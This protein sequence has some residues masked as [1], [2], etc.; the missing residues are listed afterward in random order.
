MA[1]LI[2]RLLIVLLIVLYAQNVMASSCTAPKKLQQVSIN[3]DNLVIAVMRVNNRPVADS[4]DLYAHDGTFFVAISQLGFL[5]DLPWH[6][7]IDNH[8]FYSAYDN[9]DSIDKLC[10]FDISL[11]STGTS[12]GYWY[13][14]DF[15]TY[16]DVLTLS[17]LFVGE[18]NFNEKLQQLN[19]TSVEADL[20]LKKNKHLQINTFFN[21]PNVDVYPIVQ[22]AYRLFSHPIVNYRVTASTQRLNGRTNTRY[23]TN[24]NANLDLMGLA[25]EYRFI[26]GSNYTAN[27]AKF[28][29]NN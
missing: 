17:H 27:F 26:H 25:S 23:Q 13:T 7:D 18:V 21:E 19:F 2:M 22:D 16:I 6:F 4:I 14:D 11:E 29:K 20:G 8:Q 3:E 5:L 24:L 15:D 28:S 9:S 12:R 1:V 10:D